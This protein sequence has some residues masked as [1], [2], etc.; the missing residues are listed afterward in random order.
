MSL[1]KSIFNKEVNEIS[2]DTLISFFE[3]ERKE[4]F[5]LEFKSGDV[6]LSKLHREISAFLNTDGGVLI[7]GAP[8][9]NIKNECHGQLIPC[10]KIKSSDTIMSSIAS[11]IM[12][13]P[14][15]IKILDFDHEGGK[16][17][18]LEI[19]KSK[20]PPHQVTAEGKYYV[21]FDKEAKPAP[22]G[23][24][25]ALFQYREKPKLETF[26]NVSE[27]ELNVFKV[28]VEILNESHL[29]AE[30]IGLIIDIY[31]VEEI[32]ERYRLN[33]FER[34]SKRYTLSTTFGNNIL[35]KGISFTE[36][37]KFATLQKYVL[38]TTSVYCL[39][40]PIYR[41]RG[42][43]DTKNKIFVDFEDGGTKYSF[44]LKETISKYE[45]LNNLN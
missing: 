39:N 16:I 26:L 34:Q 32:I 45:K 43:F 10:K 9:E 33:S 36:D 30:N 6:E 5:N 12:P 13:L 22:H 20:T 21:R 11:N 14:E 41:K 27:I 1:L 15:N 38:I 4:S 28:K 37:F 25:K 35:V 42:L 31:G 18:I 7:L 23:I 3:E 24:V 8:K 44:D 29:T 19:P 2:L 40:S 17:F